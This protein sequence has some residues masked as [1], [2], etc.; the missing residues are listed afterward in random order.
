VID[1]AKHCAAS[2]FIR[3]INGNTG[4]AAGYNIDFYASITGSPMRLGRILEIASFDLGLGTTT[5][6][7]GETGDVSRNLKHAHPALLTIVLRIA[8]GKIEVETMLLTSLSLK[9]APTGSK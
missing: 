7:N 2:I 9:M 8:P 5:C 1:V 6:T 4:I 3:V